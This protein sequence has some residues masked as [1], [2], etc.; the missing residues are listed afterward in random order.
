MSEQACVCG[1]PFS[2]HRLNRKIGNRNECWAMNADP[3][4]TRYCQCRAYQAAAPSSAESGGDG[5]A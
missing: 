4:K 3:M 1:H 5:R 2:I